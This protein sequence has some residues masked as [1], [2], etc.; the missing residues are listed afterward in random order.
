MLIIVDVLVVIIWL[1]L[2]VEI[3]NKWNTY[4]RYGGGILSDIGI[5]ISESGGRL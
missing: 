3:H 2:Y 1:L 5:E 4:T